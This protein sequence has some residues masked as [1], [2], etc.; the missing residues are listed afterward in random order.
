MNIKKSVPDGLFRCELS[1][2]SLSQK[3]RVNPEIRLNWVV[4]MQKL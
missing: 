4:L 2:L 3:V 1:K